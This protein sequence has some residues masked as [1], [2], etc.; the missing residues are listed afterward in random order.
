MGRNRGQRGCVRS[1]GATSWSLCACLRTHVQGI[2][3]EWRRLWRWGEQRA[4]SRVS[5]SSTRVSSCDFCFPHFLPRQPI[6]GKFPLFPQLLQ[7][8][9]VFGKKNKKVVPCFL[10][11]S[12]AAA[13]ISPPPHFPQCYLFQITLTHTHTYVRSPPTPSYTSVSMAPV[14]AAECQHPPPHY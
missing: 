7:V 13:I 6:V 11:S 12:T 3:N 1:P 14:H 10:P 2:G 8:F 4:L 5:A 9:V